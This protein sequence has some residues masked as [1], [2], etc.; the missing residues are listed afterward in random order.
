MQS[1]V[2]VLSPSLN[3]PARL[4]RLHRLAGHTIHPR[5]VFD[6]C[7]LTYV[8]ERYRYSFN[9]GE[10]R[11][12]VSHFA[13]SVNVAATEKRRWHIENNQRSATPKLTV[14]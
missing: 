4:R 2:I 10:C 14:S 11:I 3:L 9:C 1:L 8:K 7:P 6:I 13:T 12:V 5:Q